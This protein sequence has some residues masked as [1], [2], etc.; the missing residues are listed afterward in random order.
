MNFNDWVTRQ[1]ADR[2]LKEPSEADRAA[3]TGQV[4]ARIKSL[5]PTPMASSRRSWWLLVWGWPRVTTVAVVV[6]VGV[7]VA[8]GVVRQ[9]GVQV[10]MQPTESPTQLAGTGG[11]LPDALGLLDVE[12]PTPV[13]AF[14]ATDDL[15]LAESSPDDGAWLLETLELLEQLDE[16]FPEDYLDDLSDDDW[17]KELELLDE[18]AF[19]TSS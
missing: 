7:L 9:Q 6:A 12:N 5:A 11:D 18:S 16:A 17:L 13:D 19:V 10:V 4:M 15:V 8:M 2:P 3:F 1:F 14:E